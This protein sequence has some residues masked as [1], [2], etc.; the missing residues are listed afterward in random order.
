MAASKAPKNKDLSNL[1]P[2]RYFAEISGFARLRP[3]SDDPEAL[4][5][6]G[7][8][9]HQRRVKP[10]PAVHDTKFQAQLLDELA[11]ATGTPLV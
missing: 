3:T 9:H 2:C 10:H 1:F 4:T 6:G 11:R 7:Y 5:S 8:W